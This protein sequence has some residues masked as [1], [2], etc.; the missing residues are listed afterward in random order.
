MPARRTLLRMFSLANRAYINSVVSFY[1]VDPDTKER[2]ETLATLYQG[3]S[4]TDT[5]PNPYT[6]DGDGKLS[7]PVYHDVPVIAV[8]NESELGQHE[9]GVIQPISS[10]WRDVWESGLVYYP[11]ELVRDGVNGL[12]TDN[13]YVSTEEHLSDVWATD[14][15]ALK[16]EIV[17]DV[18]DVTE[19]TADALNAAA[20]A[21]T[22]A[23]TATTGAAT[24]TI[25]AATATTQASAASASA[26]QAAASAAA[27]SSFKFAVTTGSSNA[28]LADF[29]PDITPLTDGQVIRLEANFTNSGSA[30]LNVD[31]SG[32]VTIKKMNDQNL[33]SGDWESGQQVLMSYQASPASWQF[34]GP[35]AQFPLTSQLR[36]ASISSP[37]AGDVL[38]WSGSVWA[39][40]ANYIKKTVA[41]V[42]T[43]QQNFGSTALT[44]SSNH[45]A[46]NLDSAQA[47]KHTFTE[48]TTLD[49]PTNMVD[50]GTYDILFTQHAS[51]PKTLAFGSA[52]KWPGAVAPTITNTNGAKDLLT[53]RSDGTN[54]YCTLTKAFG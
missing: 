8:I 15:A 27:I 38:E 10:G 25:Q 40:V 11:G 36:D 16:W 43:K 52:Y 33:E 44:S 24:A 28:Y 17:L 4:G 2:E 14:L 18:Q 5:V 42:F 41:N 6:L 31:G 7:A 23:S 47:A 39:N 48:N 35:V 32:A 26:A 29:S 46:W 45:I 1:T 19:A 37:A 54:M 49:N 9:T 53:C 12:S 3:L 20:S 34:L 22:S 50:G 13:I 21:A 51:S 30:T